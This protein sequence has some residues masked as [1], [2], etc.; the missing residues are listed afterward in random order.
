MNRKTTPFTTHPKQ[1]AD[2]QRLAHAVRVSPPSL[3][4]V[5]SPCVP[6]EAVPLLILARGKR[7]RD[8][9][10]GCQGVS[11]RTAMPVV[12]MDVHMAEEWS[13]RGANAVATM[14]LIKPACAQA[15]G[16]V[17]QLLISVG[18]WAAAA[19]GRGVVRR[20]C[21]ARRR[22]ARRCGCDIERELATSY[23]RSHSAEPSVYLGSFPILACNVGL[24]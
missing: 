23:G 7:G 13:A 8:R 5:M 6:V 10:H 17:P 11:A 16:R 9:R 24:V 18:D 22:C 20:A 2:I 1:L 4:I 12:G 15:D 21:A 14:G 19:S 3:S